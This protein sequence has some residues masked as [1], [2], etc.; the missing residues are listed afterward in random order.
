M[1]AK[2]KCPCCG[3]CGK[4]RSHPRTYGGGRTCPECNGTGVAKPKPRAKRKSQVVP[5]PRCDEAKVD[6]GWIIASHSEGEFVPLKLARSLE[7]ENATLRAKLAVWDS[8]QR[9]A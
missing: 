9:D 8:I 6:A 3:G 5:N 4:V 7:S 1:K 2:P